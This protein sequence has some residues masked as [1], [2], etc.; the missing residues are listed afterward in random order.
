MTDARIKVQDYGDVLAQINNME[1]VSYEEEDDYQG[2]YLA[3][4]KDKDRLFYY[5]GS[6]GSCSGC[7]WLQDVQDWKDGTVSY[8]DALDYCQDMKPR[9]IVPEDRPLIMKV[10]GYGYKP[11]KAIEESEEK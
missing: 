10:V 8:K 5:T 6:F 3:V 2:Q 4:L 9:Y 7:D 1:L 11:V